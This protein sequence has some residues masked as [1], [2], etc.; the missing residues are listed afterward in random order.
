MLGQLKLLSRSY[1]TN[2][3]ACKVSFAF[4]AGVRERL[5]LKSMKKWSYNVREQLTNNGD[6][7]ASKRHA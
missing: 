7:E 6:F 2:R 4:S 1:I 5:L 3:H